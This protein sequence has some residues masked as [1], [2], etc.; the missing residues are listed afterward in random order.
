SARL[1]LCTDSA[2][3]FFPVEADPDLGYCLHRAD[4]AT[5]KVLALAGRHEVRDYLDV[6]FLHRDYLSLGALCWAACG[7]DQ[8]YNPASLL[9]MA[10]RHVCYRQEQLDVG[11]LREP[12]RL[13]DLKQQWNEA[14]AQAE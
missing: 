10:R 8:G 14:A 7:K 5:N 12:L 11:Q 2:F 6:L 3:R 9:D 4:L 1:D 13:T